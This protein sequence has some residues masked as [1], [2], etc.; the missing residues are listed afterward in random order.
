MEN[1]QNGGTAQRTQ[2]PMGNGWETQV[3]HVSVTY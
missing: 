3:R 1:S 2:A